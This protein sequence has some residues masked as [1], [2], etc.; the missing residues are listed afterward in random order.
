MPMSTNP[1]AGISSKRLVDLINAT[2]QSQLVEGV[3]FRFGEP[4][5]I[6]GAEGFNT[7][8]RLHRLTAQ[9]AADIDIEYTRRPISDLADLPEGIIGTLMF[10]TSSFRVH[11]I[12][13]LINAEYGLNLLPHEVVNERFVGHRD[14]FPLTISES[15][16]AWEPGSV[17]M[18]AVKSNHLAQVVKVKLL[19]GLYPPTELPA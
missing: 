12:L 10:D 7:R 8:V 5:A 14:S 1:Y 19:D 17:F 2:N 18:M 6:P 11:D 13:G 16:L 15:S 9:Y 4:R 3:D